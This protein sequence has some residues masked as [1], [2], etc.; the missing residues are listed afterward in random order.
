M[1]R[2][3]AERTSVREGKHERGKAGWR[4]LVFGALL[5]LVGDCTLRFLFLHVGASADY[6]GQALLAIL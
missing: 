1:P 5:T 2:N 6:V 3:A 4:I